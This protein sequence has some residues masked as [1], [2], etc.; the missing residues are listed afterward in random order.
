MEQTDQQVAEVAE[1]KLET[2]LSKQSQK[3]YED[4][5]QMLKESKFKTYMEII[6]IAMEMIEKIEKM[7]KSKFETLLEILK[8]LI[9]FAPLV[10]PE[11]QKTNMMPM[12]MDIKSL[13][14]NN[15][16][17]SVIDGL[18]FASKGVIKVNIKKPKW[19]KCF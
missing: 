6:T 3:I 12:I 4:I 11:P 19:C 7:E 16:L 8:E 9:Q 10:L 1:V 2:I 14:E 15:L 17:K 5:F 18:I 13:I